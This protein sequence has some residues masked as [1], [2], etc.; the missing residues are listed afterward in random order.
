MMKKKLHLLKHLSKYPF[1]SFFTSSTLHWASIKHA[2]HQAAICFCA[3][4]TAPSFH[5]LLSLFLSSHFSHRRLF[6]SHKA[7][8]FACQSIQFSSERFCLA[9]V[10]FT[11]LTDL[12]WMDYA[13]SVG[14]CF[15]VGWGFTSSLA[16]VEYQTRKN[17]SL[18]HNLLRLLTLCIL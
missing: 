3:P 9:L 2:R 13:I 14:N 17:T 5:S 4:Y 10:C 18:F 12:K 11:I 16:D 8:E 6:E 15:S 7:L 1:S